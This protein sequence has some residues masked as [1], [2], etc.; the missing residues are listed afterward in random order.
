MIIATD[1]FQLVI[2]SKK[3]VEMVIAII[4]STINCCKV[5][6]VRYIHFFL[7]EIKQTPLCED[8][9]AKSTTTI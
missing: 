4:V 7:F 2:Y 8:K 5:P 9:E 3:P 6:K 1:P